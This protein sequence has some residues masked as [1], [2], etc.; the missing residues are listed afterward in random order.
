MRKTNSTEFDVSQRPSAV[1]ACG[2]D[3]RIQL[4]FEAEDAIDIRSPDHHTNADTAR[5]P[6]HRPAAVANATSTASHAHLH[7]HR[8]H[9]R[10]RA[11][12]PRHRSATP[13]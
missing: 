7:H 4:E 1:V 11:A 13:T 6:N 12:V 10:R 3:G 5:Q 9:Q 8:R 2:P